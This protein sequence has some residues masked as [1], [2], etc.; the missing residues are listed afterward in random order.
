MKVAGYYEVDSGVQVYILNWKC[1]EK[2]LATN[3]NENTVRPGKL[4][5][6]HLLRPKVLSMKLM[7]SFKFTR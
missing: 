6:T 7:T 2:G 1:L 5:A 3:N 4:I